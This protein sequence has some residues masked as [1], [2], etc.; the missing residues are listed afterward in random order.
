MVLLDLTMAATSDPQLCQQLLSSV[1][2]LLNTSG[3]TTSGTYIGS[4]HMFTDF[5]GAIYVIHYI[6]LF[7][8]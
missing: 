7:S 3:K 8:I 1:Q 2:K 4:F 5:Y 6:D